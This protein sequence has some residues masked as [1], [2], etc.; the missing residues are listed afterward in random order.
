MIDKLVLKCEEVL[1]KNHSGLMQEEFQRVSRSTIFLPIRRLLSCSPQLLDQEQ[2]AD[3]HRMYLLLSRIPNGLDPLR[4]RFEIHVKKAGLE[5]VEK[6]AGATPDNVVRPLSDTRSLL[7]TDA[8]RDHRSQK[9]TSTP[10]LPCT[11][12]TLSLSPRPSVVTRDSSHRSI[13]CVSSP[14]IWDSSTDSLVPF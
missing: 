6:T 13:R 12:R 7:S 9:H 5:S 11:R 10:S 3:L 14:S 4:E 8:R 2:E 1:V